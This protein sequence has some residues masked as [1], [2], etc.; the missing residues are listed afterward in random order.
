L[1][2]EDCME[3]HIKTGHEDYYFM[4]PEEAIS[5]IKEK[6]ELEALWQDL[7]IKFEEVSKKS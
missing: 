1:L 4:D 2:C 6:N 7:S 3:T 5:K